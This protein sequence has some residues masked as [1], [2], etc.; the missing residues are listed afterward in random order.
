LEEAGLDE[1]SRKID[2]VL[3]ERLESEAARRPAGLVR[4]LGSPSF[5]RCAAFRCR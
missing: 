4:Q 5:G 2:D 1:V 3:N